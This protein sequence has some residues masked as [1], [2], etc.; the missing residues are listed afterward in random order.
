MENQQ[1]QNEIIV[2]SGLPRSG[3]S[4]MMQMLQAGGLP[5]YFDA[6]RPADAHNPKGYLELDAVKNLRQNVAWLDQA[7]GKAVKIISHHIQA[8]PAKFYYRIIFMQ[9]DLKEVVLS[10]NKM[11]LQTGKPLGALKENELAE[12]FKNHLTR[13]LRWLQQQN[14]IDL[15]DVSYSDLLEKPEHWAELI[16]KFLNKK[17]DVTKMIGQV[18]PS[19]HRIKLTDILE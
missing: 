1:T 2:V 4:L 9:R 8:L 6:A 13:V 11:L 16:V 14:N 17:L 15:L 5:L 19:L 7:K 10:Q 3:T 18:E 12:Y